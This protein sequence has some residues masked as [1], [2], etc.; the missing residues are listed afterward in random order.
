MI[1]LAGTAHHSFTF[2]ADCRAALGY[3][4]DARRTLS[5]LPH[6][7]I[8]KE[9][10]RDRFRLWY[11]ATELGIYQVLLSCDIQ[12]EP[13]WENGVLRIH[14][15]KSGPA[16]PSQ[17]GMYSLTAPATFQSESIFT[18]AGSQTQVDYRLHLHAELPTPLAV[19]LLPKRVLDG[20]AHSISD[21]RMD[22]IAVRFIERSIHLYQSNEEKVL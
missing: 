17:A 16:V 15:L 20:I 12:V 2:P 10:A 19:R 4:C 5:C 21:R 11:R 6:I 18:G 9:Y 13:D 3:F 1:T 22:E 7:T 8:L 14:P